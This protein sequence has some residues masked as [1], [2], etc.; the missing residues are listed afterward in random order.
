MRSCFTCPF[1]FLRF[2]CDR[3]LDSPSWLDRWPSSSK[4]QGAMKIEHCSNIVSQI[5]AE[6]RKNVL[7]STFQSQVPSKAETVYL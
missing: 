5:T 7:S 6:K 2:V 4:G 3:A 1:G